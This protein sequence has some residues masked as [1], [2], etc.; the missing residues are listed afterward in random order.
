MQTGLGKWVEP[1]YALIALGIV[2]LGVV[3]VISI[4]REKI[5]SPSQNQVAI[6]GQGK[7]LYQPDVANVTLGVQVDKVATSL[8]ALEQLNEKMTNVTNALESVGIPKTDIETQNYSLN[9]QYDYKT[10]VQIAAGYDAN[11]KLVVKI[12]DIQNNPQKVS[13]VIAAVGQAGSNQMLGITFDVSNINDLKQQAR[14]LA[15]ADAR[16]KSKTLAK[17]AGV[18]LGEVVGWY[19]NALQSPENPGV[20]SMGLG[21]PA[22]ME[23]SV[24]AVPQ[25]PTGTQEIVIEVSLNYNVK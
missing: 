8:Q 11:Q 16:T 1:K 4:V 3:V 20:S 13:E 17:A 22:M 7:I 6:A 19:E 25:I 21:G 24:A 10:G 23:K 18:E 14:L 2:V 15:I 12:K 5:V 9:T